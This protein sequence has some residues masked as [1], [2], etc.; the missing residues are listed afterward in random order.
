MCRD[1]SGELAA[2]GLARWC[3]GQTRQGV[4][5]G[6]AA[7]SAFWETVQVPEGILSVKAVAINSE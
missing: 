7:T 3:V 5:D 6:S 2:N 1:E 4:T